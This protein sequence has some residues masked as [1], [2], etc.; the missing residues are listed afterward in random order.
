MAAVLAAWKAGP[1]GAI[2]EGLGGGGG[3]CVSVCVVVGAAECGADRRARDRAERPLAARAQEKIRPE[4]RRRRWTR[5]AAES[6]EK[7]QVVDGS[8]KAVACSFSAAGCALS[9]ALSTLANQ[10]LSRK[11]VKQHLRIFISA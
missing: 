6:A 11:Q 5:A 10:P 3:M 2:G 4:L 1:R 9:K 8:I 7:Q